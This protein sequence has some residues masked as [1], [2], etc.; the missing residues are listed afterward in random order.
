MKLRRFLSGEPSLSALAGLHDPLWTRFRTATISSDD[1][2]VVVKEDAVVYKMVVPGRSEEQIDI[3]VVKDSLLVKTQAT[4]WLPAQEFT[5]GLPTNRQDFKADLQDGV[6][7]IT[8]AL[9]KTAN[10][11][12]KITI[13]KK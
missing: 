12:S 1:Y 8:V 10:L 3:E 13:N 6:L 9:A 2:D 4:D 7:T 11:N 5:F